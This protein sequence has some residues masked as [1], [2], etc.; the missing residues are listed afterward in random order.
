MPVYLQYGLTPPLSLMPDSPFWTNTMPTGNVIDD[1]SSSTMNFIGIDSTY[2]ADGEFCSWLK[3]YS[4][5]SATD[6]FMYL[7][8]FASKPV[9]V[10]DF[11][12]ISHVSHSPPLLP[13]VYSDGS[14][15]HPTHPQ[16]GLSTCATWWPHRRLHDD[17]QLEQEFSVVKQQ[18]AGVSASVGLQGYQSSSTRAE[19]MGAIIAI[20]S[21][22][23]VHLALDNLSV[24]CTAQ[25]FINN[26]QKFGFDSSILFSQMHNGDLWKIFY[27]VAFKRNCHSIAI[28]WTKGHA[29]SNHEYLHKHPHLKYQ[30]V[31]N[32]VVDTIAGRA[33]YEFF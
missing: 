27:H 20:L 25:N 2:A 14:F 26:L 29:L 18:S 9:S 30:A 28:S 13:N 16:F 24:V 5:F 10:D 17:D 19:L 7:N 33:Q 32:D 4:H 6:A 23:P 22:H 11:D 12:C 1:L 21:S 31:L 8:K 3:E 15:T